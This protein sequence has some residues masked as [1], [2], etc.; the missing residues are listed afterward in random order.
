MKN[1]RLI[2]ENAKISPIF[3]ILILTY[4][5]YSNR[6]AGQNLHVWG[7]EIT[8]SIE[9]RHLDYANST[10]PN[11]IYLQLFHLTH[12]A[13]TG[14]LE[15][16]RSVNAGLLTITIAFIYGV[17]RRFASKNWA[18]LVASASALSPISTYS[19][20]FMPDIM[21]FCGVAG[22]A[23]FYLTQF[24]DKLKLKLFVLGVITGGLAL[25]KPHA[26]FILIA[27]IAQQT[28]LLFLNH[29][30]RSAKERILGLTSC[31]SAFIAIRFGIGFL[32][33]GTPS[34]NLI[35][36]YSDY[37]NANW[38]LSK[39]KHAAILC[40]TLIKGHSIALV[41]LAGPGLIA[42]ITT[43]QLNWSQHR[44]VIE[45][46]SL[47]IAF[48]AVMFPLSILFSVRIADGAPFVDTMRLHMRY[49]NLFFPLLLISLLP[50]IDQTTKLTKLGR[51]FSFA[52]GLI[53]QSAAWNSLRKFAPLAV[54]S[55]ELRGITA[56]QTSM[57]IG[58]LLVTAAIW[59]FIWSPRIAARASLIFVAPFIA[60]NGLYWVNKDLTH[61]HIDLIGDI[62]GKITKIHLGDRAKNIGFFGDVVAIYQGIFY[63]GDPG[64]FTYRLPDGEG[65]PD[66]LVVGK[67]MPGYLLP[68]GKLMPPN[69]EWAVIF[70]AR[71]I[72]PRYQ[73]VLQGE[74]W[75]LH[76]RLP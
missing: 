65:V 9:S 54:D 51:T 36:A 49:Y 64:S 43:A 17:A 23:W 74:G 20:Y 58:S 69:T 59:T 1:I 57:I 47:I 31:V 68:P 24:D 21:Y 8:Y 13:K 27:F 62:A 45:L 76:R 35:G 56:N 66:E 71:P 12:A 63:V 72:P 5:Y 16:A 70:G 55:P 44:K 34:L 26:I 18:C 48:F 15:A 67:P 11:Y 14:F 3:I 7:D 25:V 42:L 60:I 28:W 73:L 29:E 53:S 32:F 19:A 50:L 75:S 4:A 46:N 6:Y 61:R 52:L 10:Y 30:S 38:D 33:A 39:F 40:L 37:T 2:F 41:L 22:F